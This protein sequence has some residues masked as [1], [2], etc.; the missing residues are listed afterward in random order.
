MGRTERGVRAAGG[1]HRADA[2]VRRP[3]VALLAAAV[4]LALLSGGGL[5]AVTGAV[6]AGSAG[7]ASEAASSGSGA[8]PTLDERGAAVL[9]WWDAQRGEAFAAGDADALAA[10]YPRG[11]P[12]AEEDLAVLAAYDARSLRVHGLRFEVHE[13]EAVTSTDDLL[14]LRVRDRL[15]RAQAR[16]EAGA[17][18]AE[19]PGRDL[20]ERVLHLERD[21]ARWVL[22]QVEEG[23]G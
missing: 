6:A 19:L 18:V 5:L 17:V 20:A 10:L 23:A 4:A 16:D 9:R 2:S 3:P 12:L 11:S 15:L 22:A 1:R 13:V 21:G 7:A 8:A 14:V